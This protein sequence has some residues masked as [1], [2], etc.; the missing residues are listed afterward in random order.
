MN[1]K[2]RAIFE[3]VVNKTKL[4]DVAKKFNRTEVYIGQL[5]KKARANKEL[6]R[7]LIDKRDQQIQL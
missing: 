3:V 1:D 7:E 5:V 6:L 2:I 4:S